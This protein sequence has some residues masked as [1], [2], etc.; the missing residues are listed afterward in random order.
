LRLGVFPEG[1]GLA[2]SR[3]G[4]GQQEKLHAGVI[5]ADL[6]AVGTELGHDPF[7]GTTGWRYLTAGHDIDASCA[8]RAHCAR[9][10]A[11]GWLIADD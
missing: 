10:G 9:L 1:I 7:L 6:P 5:A 11:A 2:C 3:A 8:N 4:R